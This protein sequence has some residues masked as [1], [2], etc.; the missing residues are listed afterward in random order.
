[1]PPSAPP[2]TAGVAPAVAPTGAAATSSRAL[3]PVSSLDTGT[4][5]AA[6]VG[7]VQIDRQA[8]EAERND[9]LVLSQSTRKGLWAYYAEDYAR[10]QGCRVGD[11]GAVLLQETVEY[12]LHEVE[13]I[14]AP[15]RLLRC[16]GGVCRAM[17]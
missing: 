7:T 11:R 12:E 10:E 5:S 15:N 8:A 13:C 4:T 16:Q 14:D 3:A 2:P 17:R 1:T 6:P 9:M